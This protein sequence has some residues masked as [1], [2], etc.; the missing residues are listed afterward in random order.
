MEGI[1]VKGKEVVGRE[2]GFCRYILVV[3]RGRTWWVREKRSKYL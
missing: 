1:G 2:G 3:R